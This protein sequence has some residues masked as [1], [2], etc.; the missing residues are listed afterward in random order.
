MYKECIFYLYLA[1]QLTEF[2]VVFKRED[3]AEGDAIVRPGISPP[4][5]ISHPDRN[6]SPTSDQPQ[7]YSWK[8]SLRLNVE[9]REM[10]RRV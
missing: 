9:I 10:S 3:N 8:E 1:S 5:S 4:C 2:L 7:A 6:P